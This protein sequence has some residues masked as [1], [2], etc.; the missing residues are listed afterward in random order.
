[1]NNINIKNAWRF[2]L[3]LIFQ[4]AVFKQL[5]LQWSYATYLHILIYPIFLI[6]LPFRYS[7]ITILLLAFALGIFVDIFYNTIGIHASTCVFTAFIRPSI[8]S[9]IKPQGDYDVL[10]SPNASDYGFVWFLRYASILL[11]L[12]LF[13]YFSVE[14][15]TF[16]YLGQ[17]ILKT[18]GSFLISII[19]V[20][21]YQFIFN[22]K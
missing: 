15:F 9:I 4:V 5:N 11:F 21:L 3:L 14:A 7:K 12:H 8:L 13:F 20:I 10:Q 6:L 16:V 2:V 19:F 17:I 22:P 1:M 18:L